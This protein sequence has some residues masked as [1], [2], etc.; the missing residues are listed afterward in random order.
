MN[1]AYPLST[2]HFSSSI[3][4]VLFLIFSIMTDVATSAPRR[5]ISWFPAELMTGA[6]VVD[7]ARG[8][9]NWVGILNMSGITMTTL[10][11]S[12]AKTIRKE[13]KPFKG[14]IYTFILINFT[15]G[16]LTIDAYKISENCDVTEQEE[17]VEAILDIHTHSCSKKQLLDVAFSLVDSSAHDLPF[18]QITTSKVNYENYYF[19]AAP[20][21]CEKFSCSNFNI[22]REYID[23]FAILEHYG[24]QSRNVRVNYQDLLFKDGCFVDHIQRETRFCTQFFTNPALTSRLTRKAAFSYVAMIN[25]TLAN[26]PLNNATGTCRLSAEFS[27]LQFHLNCNPVY[28]RSGALSDTELA[29]G[30]SCPLAMQWYSKELLFDRQININLF[31]KIMSA[32][33]HIF[34]RQYERDKNDFYQACHQNHKD[35]DLHN[36]IY[37]SFEECLILVDH[38]AFNQTE[39]DFA[40]E[41]TKLKYVIQ[42]GRCNYLKSKQ[43]IKLKY[44]DTHI[45]VKRAPDDMEESTAVI[46]GITNIVNQISSSKVTDTYHNEVL[47]MN[48]FNSLLGVNEMTISDVGKVNQNVLDLSY[49]VTR[50]KDDFKLAEEE[51]RSHIMTNQGEIHRVKMQIVQTNEIT[52]KQL[53]IVI[54]RYYTQRIVEKTDKFGDL[55]SAGSDVTLVPDPINPDV[56]TLVIRKA[57]KSKM[58]AKQL[59]CHPDNLTGL[60]PDIDYLADGLVVRH[61][62]QKIYGECVKKDEVVCKDLLIKPPAGFHGIRVGN[63]IKQTGIGGQK[64]AIFSASDIYCLINHKKTKVKS[65]FSYF[66]KANLSYVSCDREIRIIGNAS[67]ITDEIQ[68]VQLQIYLE[69]PTFTEEAATLQA[70][71]IKEHINSKVIE[72][73]NISGWNETLNKV[74]NEHK[75]LIEENKPEKSRSWRQLA[76]E[77]LVYVVT[78]F[79][80]I[81]LGT[82]AICCILQT[83][84]QKCMRFNFGYNKIDRYL[85]KRREN[86][87]AA[88]T[89]LRDMVET[90]RGH[91]E[92]IV[93]LTVNSRAP[94][95]KLTKANYQHQ[96][97]SRATKDALKLWFQEN[98]NKQTFTKVDAASIVAG[99]SDE[100]ER[101]RIELMSLFPTAAEIIPPLAE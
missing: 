44:F 9:G 53:F 4:A 84:F 71:N 21:L 43:K 83:Y 47:L 36:Y 60:V 92:N 58:I 62:G 30:C 91:L 75:K 2:C 52:Q 45:R 15:L 7:A 89:E 25:S 14:S 100:D 94:I 77:I 61:S 37:N 101:S 72:I 31:N 50:D 20:V 16:L 22:L 76:I 48:S 63:F 64:V 40:Y 39:R 66:N 93:D 95:M 49:M 90:G 59:H 78:A 73:A 70:V 57:T 6:T 87:Q 55:G 34:S 19:A 23:S 27:K 13:N 29:H 98:P 32:I 38:T 33:S 24:K 5:T 99:L 68:Q 1:G 28:S 97:L 41:C 11:K 12:I 46:N 51:F 56:V 3:W 54:R 65:G 82:T 17:F 74:F 69:T 18:S 8:R 35:S 80:T 96:M 67:S 86:V 79:L 42:S 88:E 26:G 10:R 81:I 85:T